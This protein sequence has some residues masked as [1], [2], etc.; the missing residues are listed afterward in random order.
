LGETLGKKLL[1]ISLFG[2]CVARGVDPHEFE[3]TGT[4][5]KALFA[6][7]A[8]A[9]FGRCTRSFLQETLWGTACYDTG[10]QSLRRALS[11]IKRVL[12]LNFSE[13]IATTN[14]EITLNLERVCFIGQPGSGAFLEGIALKEAGFNEWLRR[15]RA[16]PAQIY[17]LYGASFQPAVRAIVPTI[18]ILPFKVVVGGPDHHVLGDWLAEEACRSLSRSNLIAVISHLSAREISKNAVILSQVRDA[19]DVD[20]CV[21]GSLR[22]SGDD[23]ILDADFLDAASGRIL[24]TR[25]FTGTMAEFL[26][27][28]GEAIAEIVRTVGRSIASDAVAHTQGRRVADIQDHHLLVA[29]IS[30]MHQLKLSSFARSRSLIEEAI[31]RA[32]RTA[33]AHAWLAEWYVMSVFNGWSADREHDT[34]KAR[35]AV[36][37]ALDIDP[38]NAF[39]MTIDGVVHNN[40]LQRLDIAEERFEMALDRNPNE[41][42]SWLLNGVLHAFRDEAQTAI[43]AVE[44]ARKLSPMD[45]FEYFYDSLSASAYLAAENYPRALE[46]A[47]RS[48]SIN[49]RHISTLR[50]KIC[51]LHNLDRHDDARAAGL[52]LMRRDPE[53][54]V[55]AYRR[56]HPATNHKLGRNVADALSAAG[57]P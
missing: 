10:R 22:V 53:F 37:R 21:S 36:A 24:W 23:I 8:T 34:A 7:L 29:G 19:L 47:E 3:V 20:Y 12:G 13:L 28:D 4:K 48:F 18:S 52:E 17:S 16:N 14:S 6:L 27:G 44:Q 35:D 25:R 31:A 57:V 39:C 33:E 46:L 56:H 43:A 32:P 26:N 30:L 50:A 45:P 54:S 1:E 49:N 51:A 38:E 40:L 15:I 9:P 5:H 2:A 41:A 11:D 55:E 42:M